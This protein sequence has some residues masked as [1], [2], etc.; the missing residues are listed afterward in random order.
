MPRNSLIVLKL[1]YG[2]HSV[3]IMT[4]MR[5]IYGFMLACVYTYVDLPQQ[6][7]RKA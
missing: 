5:A 6:H 3:N 1:T 2:D 4:R 7:N